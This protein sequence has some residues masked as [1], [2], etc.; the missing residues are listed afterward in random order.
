MENEDWVA[1]GCN[2][3][4]Q[5]IFT[6][7]VEKHSFDTLEARA[8][9]L[10]D[11]LDERGYSCWAVDEREID[12]KMVYYL[13]IHD[14]KAVEVPKGT[15]MDFPWEELLYFYEDDKVFQVEMDESI[16]DYIWELILDLNKMGLF[17]YVS[18]SGLVEDHISDFP[19]RGACGPYVIFDDCVKRPIIDE[20]VSGTD[21][22]VE[23]RHFDNFDDVVIS[24]EGANDKETLV[25][26]DM[27][28]ESLAKLNYGEKES[29]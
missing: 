16:D 11:A 2:C 19:Y 26:W 28:K 6:K 20:L 14:V 17:T 22:V 25:A 29:G 24:V 7:T 13:E 18:C 12:G 10:K 3:L 27:L 21:W 23:E 4:G 8:I 1:G 5:Q 9:V 15:M